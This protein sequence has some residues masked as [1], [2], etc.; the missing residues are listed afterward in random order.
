MFYK[1]FDSEY[2]VFLG[3]YSFHRINDINIGMMLVVVHYIYLNYYISL[4]YVLQ[5]L[6][7][8]Q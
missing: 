8:D 4:I 6:E 3:L 7:K 2:I 1:V 5:Y